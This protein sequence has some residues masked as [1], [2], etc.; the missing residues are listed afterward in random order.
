[1]AKARILTGDKQL[2]ATLRDMATAGANRVAKSTIRAGLNVMQSEIKKAAKGRIKD[3]IGKKFKNIGRTSRLEAKTGVGVGKRKQ[4][5]PKKEPIGHFYAVGTKHRTRKRIG[6]RFGYLKNPTKRQ[7]STGQM[8]ARPFV[9]QAVSSA[10]PT[11]AAKMKAAATKALDREAQ[12]ADKAKYNH[13]LPT[14]D[15]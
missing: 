6:G 3:E 10:A 5:D 8:P 1:M 15:K 9:K 2:D 14:H 7:L 13:H 11:A 12:R 4:T